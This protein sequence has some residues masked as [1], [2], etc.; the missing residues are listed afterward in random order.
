MTWDA[1]KIYDLLI[2]S[3][4]LSVRL[5]SAIVNKMNLGQPIDGYLDHLYLIDNLIFAIEEGASDFEDVDFDYLY[6]MYTKLLS[7]HNRYKGL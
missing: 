1:I 6:G 3:K 7:K 4:E 5:A 2:D